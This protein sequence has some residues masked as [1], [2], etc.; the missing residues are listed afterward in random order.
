[1]QATN[2]LQKNLGIMI[3]GWE[4]TLDVYNKQIFNGSD[5][6]ITR[7]QNQIKDGQVLSADFAI[8]TQQVQTLM[9]KAIYGYL[10]PQAWSLSNKDINPVVM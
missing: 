8:D 1:M 9:A 6:S 10:I 4:Q 2:D 7:L 3:G 5:S